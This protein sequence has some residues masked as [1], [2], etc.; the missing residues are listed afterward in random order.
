MALLIKNIDDLKAEIYHLKVKEDQQRYALRQRFNSPSKIFTT[1]KSLF[2]KPSAEGLKTDSGR[3]KDY[4][5]ILAR[6]ILPVT[7]KRTVFR[8]SNFIVKSLVGFASKKASKFITEDSV[9]GAWNKIKALL[10]NNKVTNSSPR[11]LL[12]VK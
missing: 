12:I 11:K 4:F 3:K 7:L 5:A 1:V 2:S 9:T 10:P 8:K 6:I